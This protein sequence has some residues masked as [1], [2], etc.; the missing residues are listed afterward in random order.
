LFQ[1]FLDRNSKFLFLINYEQTQILENH[2]FSHQTVCTNKDIYFPLFKII[3]NLL[4]FL[5]SACTAQV[6]HL[7]RKISQTISK[8]V[9]MLGSQNS[10]WH[11]NS[12]LFT[13]CCCLKCRSNSYLRFSESYVSTD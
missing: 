1:L 10:S 7:Y 11:Q 2:I 3:E 4:L 8:C 9:V 13:I 12:C 5:C 6:I